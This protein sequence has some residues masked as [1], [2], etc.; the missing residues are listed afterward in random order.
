[1]GRFVN[2]I[3]QPWHFCKTTLVT[4][5]EIS[6]KVS[7]DVLN[8]TKIS[9]EL[10]LDVDKLHKALNQTAQMASP[11]WTFDIQVTVLDEIRR[12]VNTWI[13]ASTASLAES[14]WK[15][16]GSHP[17]WC[18]DIATCILIVLEDTTNTPAAEALAQLWLAVDDLSTTSNESKLPDVMTSALSTCFDEGQG[19]KVQYAVFL[20]QLVTYGVLTMSSLVQEYLMPLLTATT[21]HLSGEAGTSALQIIRSI[22]CANQIGRLLHNQLTETSATTFLKVEA[23]LEIFYTSAQI[24]E[25]FDLL[26]SLCRL[27]SV[28]QARN[29]EV[30][31]LLVRELRLKMPRNDRFQ[32]LFMRNLVRVS[33]KMLDTSGDDM[34][35]AVARVDVLR[36]VIKALKSRSGVQTDPI[37]PISVPTS[38]STKHCT[39]SAEVVVSRLDQMELQAYLKHLEM[40]K[41]SEQFEDPV[42]AQRFLEGLLNRPDSLTNG[43]GQLSAFTG[44]GADQ[45]S[46]SNIHC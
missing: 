39:L 3:F 30:H 4:L 26:I 45:V 14:Y 17:Q 15:M 35:T 31:A 23:A 2:S 28:L 34:H 42:F 24:C 13:P 27:E 6:P 16:Y 12:H 33:E 1:M 18:S 32:R 8:G 43:S 20:S 11:D 37:G 9:Y 38:D 21:K 29:D 36:D 40:S 46:Q 10:A 22:K 19:P 7:P 44:S 41:T 5:V 25:I